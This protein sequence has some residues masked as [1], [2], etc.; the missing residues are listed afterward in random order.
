MGRLIFHVDVNSAFLSWE[1]ARRVARGEADLRQVPSAIGGDAHRGVVVA[2]SIPA[3]ALGVRTGESVASALRKCPGLLVV[4]PDFALYARN[5][6]AFMD[7]CRR[8]APVVEKFSI[9]ECFLDM[10]G[11]ERLCPDPL[12]LAARIKDEIRDELGFTVNVGVAPNKLLAKMASD[13]EKPDR[14]HALFPEELAEKLWPL[15]VGALY[16]VGSATARRLTAAGIRNIGDLARSDPARIGELVGKKFGRQICRFANGIDDSPVLA[17]PDQ[18]KGYSNSTTLERDISSA[19]EAHRILLALADSCASRM[20][21]D[22]ARARCVG[23]TMRDAAFRD[24]SHQRKLAQ[25]TDVTD[26]IY[27]LCRQLFDARWDGRS[28]LRLLGVSLTELSRD[29]AEQLSLFPDARREKN[30]KLD[31]TVDDIR[32]RFGPDTI[33]RGAV[34]RAGVQVGRK[35]RAQAELEADASGGRNKA[36]RET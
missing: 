20:R 19:E 1:A 13:F 8:H 34:L 29:G 16:S 36:E 22:G 21:A 14:V 15:P 2:K 3:K 9:D 23:V 12:A 30:V 5:S 7:I 4:P 11:M 10:S 24:R 31:R 6:R 28:P 26:E 32:R 35:H 17:E 25:P 33:A 27:A 18:L